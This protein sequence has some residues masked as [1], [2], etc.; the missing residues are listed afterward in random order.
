[1]AL[2][3]AHEPGVFDG[4]MII[5]SAVRDE[6]DRSSS[7]LQSWRP[8][9]VGD[10]TEY[11]V[12]CTHHEMLTAESLSM[13]GKQLKDS[14]VRVGSTEVSGLFGELAAGSR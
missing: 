8:Y 12:D 7:L 9:V 4:D 11:S 14:L 2:H 10:I 13:Y 3:R 1:M 5:F 6:S